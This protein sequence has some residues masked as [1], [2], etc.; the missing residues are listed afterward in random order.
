MKYAVLIL[1]FCVA[2]FAAVPAHAGCGG[3]AVQ[4]FGH[5][6]VQSFAVAP[7]FVA[8]NPFAVHSFASPFVVA[9]VGHN[10]AAQ[11]NVFGRNRAAVQVN[12]AG[13]NVRV[14]QG[15]FGGTRVLVR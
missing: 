2:L 11:V 13:A 3:V 9:N 10:R 5:C 15:I 6:G 8:V 1:L 4:S 12:A 7:S 14:R